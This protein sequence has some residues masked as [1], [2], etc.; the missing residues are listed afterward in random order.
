MVVRSDVAVEAIGHTATLPDDISPLRIGAKLTHARHTYTLLGRARMG[1]N[2]GAWS[3]WFMDD[4]TVQ[5]WLTEAQ[6]FLSVSFGQPLPPPLATGSWPALGAEITLD[7]RVYRVSDLK[8]ATCI[9]SEG[10]LPFAAP[11]GRVVRYADMIGQSA[12]FASLEESG[13]ERRLYT[14]AYVSFD[15]LSFEN[16][17]PVDGWTRPR[18]GP[19]TAGD[20]Q[21]LPVP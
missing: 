4:G 11:G 20:P 6:G 5:G 2:D 10:E 21:F 1:W 14:G 18:S 19:G 3:E 17:R 13:D 15:D 9:G 7:G 12:G 16:L 8:Q